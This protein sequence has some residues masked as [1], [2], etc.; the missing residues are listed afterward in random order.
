MTDSPTPCIRTGIQ[1]GGVQGIWVQQQVAQCCGGIQGLSQQGEEAESSAC[2]QGS[3][4]PM[5]GPHQAENEVDTTC[6]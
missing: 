4:E 2:Y 3:R 6:H 5:L 1:T